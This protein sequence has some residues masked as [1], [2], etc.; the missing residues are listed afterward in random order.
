MWW[1]VLRITAAVRAWAI[2]ARIM[3]SPLRVR[4]SVSGQCQRPE[5]LQSISLNTLVNFS[6]KYIMEAPIVVGS[7][8]SNKIQEN[9]LTARIITYHY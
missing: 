1:A 8:L 6:L 4:L 2:S 3:G 9:T 7:G 5:K